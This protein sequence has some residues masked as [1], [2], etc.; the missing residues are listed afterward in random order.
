VSDVV[1]EPLSGGAP[2]TLIG[3]QHAVP[4]LGYEWA[5]YSISG[6]ASAYSRQRSELAVVEEADYTTRLM[7]L[8]P[9]DPTAFNGTVW[10]EWL[11][12][13][14]GLDAAPDWGFVHTEAMRAGA[15]WVCVSAQQI[16]VHGGD[17]LVS[18]GMPTPGLVGSDPDRYGTLTHP[19]DRF[20]Y[21]IFSQAGAAARRGSGTTL[22]GLP[23]ER[24]V[25]IGESQS[26]FRLTT[27]ANDVDPVAQVFDGF[28]VHARGRTGAPLDDD[29]PAL[30]LDADPV[31][32]R[33]DRR[34]PILCVEA[35]TD[36]INLGYASARQEDDDSFALWEIAGTSHADVYVL[37]VNMIDTGRLPIAELAAA[38]RPTYEVLGMA[39][40]VPVNT[41][42][43]HYVMN[44]AV[45]HFDRWLRDG[46]RPPAAPRL[47]MFDGAFVTD[48]HGNVRGGI[49]SPHVDV[50]TAILSGLSNSTSPLAFLAG[51]TTPF[52]ATK[53]ASL[54]ASRADYLARFDAATDA[55]V[56]A[57]FFLATD[58]PEVKAVARENC[59][60][61]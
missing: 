50:P 12:V 23:I 10:V 51:S 36:L 24:V 13:S 57:G 44:A 28:L 35:E 58:A 14:G 25:A 7:V 21:D 22:G 9:V 45:S 4:Q 33:T 18:V 60:I 61:A 55:A 15:A 41:G 37:V 34:V 20:S 8:R 6:T 30:G 1:I 5:E 48:E 43:Q 38:W 27:Y 40:D 2:P 56:A 31:L 3:V 46:T 11:N 49:R 54:Y 47:E 16:G 29:G 53:L 17:A 52:D 59:P 19:G 42:P 39:L 26:A 32:F